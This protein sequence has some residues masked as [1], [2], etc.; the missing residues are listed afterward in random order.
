MF[1]MFRIKFASAKVSVHDDRMVYTVG[2]GCAKRSAIEANEVI[3][4]LKLNLIAIPNEFPK[5]DTFVV[6]IMDI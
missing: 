5:D 6:K 2:Y 1:E 3:E 4:S